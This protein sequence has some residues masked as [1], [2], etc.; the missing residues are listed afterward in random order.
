M[1]LVRLAK[2]IPVILIDIYLWTTFT[3]SIG[4]NRM[5]AFCSV[6]FRVIEYSNIKSKERVILGRYRVPKSKV[7]IVLL[8]VKP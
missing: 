7:C 5:T 1:S 2:F 3:V 6:E 8:W 4:P